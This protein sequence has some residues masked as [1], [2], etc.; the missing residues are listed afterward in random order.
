ML[1]DADLSMVL[2]HARALA[3]AADELDG[4]RVDRAMA[5]EQA[6]ARWL[7]PA[8]DQFR[9]RV[10]HEERAMRVRAERLRA[11]ADRWAGIWARTVD[12]TRAARSGGPV[13][14]PVAVPT[15]A[16]GYAPTG[17]LLGDG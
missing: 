2:I 9:A 3:A 8:A 14:E 17:A 1:F 15:A 4:I 16:S 10:E 12:R 6:L 11:D 13:S 7:G 5:A